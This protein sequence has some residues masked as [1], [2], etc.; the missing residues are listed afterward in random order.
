MN[1]EKQNKFN[2]RIDAFKKKLS[3]AKKDL[4]KQKKISKNLEYIIENNIKHA[5]TFRVWQAYCKVRDFLIKIVKNPYKIVKM[6]RIFLR[7][8][9]KGIID[10]LKAN[11][12][13]SMYFDKNDFSIFRETTSLKKPI[14]EKISVVIPTRNAGNE[15]EKNL[16]SITKQRGIKEIEVIIIDNYSTDKTVNIALSKE[17]KIIKIKNFS[18]SRSRNMGAK[19]SKGDYI[20]F[21]VQDAFF[22]DPYSFCKLINF[23]KINDLAA[24][25]GYQ[26]PYKN[27]D[28]FA[29]W[30][31]TRHYDFM[32]P[33]RQNIIYKGNPIS[34]KF[35]M[36]E[37]LAKRKLIN[38]DDVFSCFRADIFKKYYFSENIR[39]AED[40]ELALKLIQN[41]Y[42]IGSAIF[43]TVYHSH[44]RN[45]IYHFKR[46]FA[47]LCTL[48]SIFHDEFQ[49]IYSNYTGNIYLILNLMIVLE[50]NLNLKGNF[51][52]YIEGGLKNE[53]TTATYKKSI[54]YR[55]FTPIFDKVNIQKNR[56]YNNHSFTI[57]KNEIQ[58]NWEVYENFCKENHYKLKKT[59]LLN[60]AAVV[61]AGYLGEVTGKTNNRSL[62]DILN[63]LTDSI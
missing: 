62:K 4:E 55:Y 7:Y 40:A 16:L 41:K 25:S 44:N 54:F 3:Q 31:F 50:L 57:F 14:Y 52:G 26:K 49:R 33:K 46:T 53:I 32:N 51:W 36:L 21:T 43:S 63:T 1:N 9:P 35:Q 27:A 56:F 39:F 17:C 42:N 48:N 59:D 10:K 8:G 6:L 34:K 24:A 18:H 28:I 30:Q 47:D 60:I 38:I 13:Q 22:D 20:F 12:N 5:K 15:F 2:A 19:I 11:K 58:T 61:L 23:I 37:F 29:K 45:F